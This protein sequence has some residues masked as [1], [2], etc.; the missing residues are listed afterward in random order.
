MT[1]AAVRATPAARIRVV[2]TVVAAF[3]EDP[4]FNYFFDK[5][6]FRAQAA[7]L[8]GY[9]FDKRVID[10]NVWVIDGGLSVSMWD[11]PD[12]D[13]PYMSLPLPEHVVDR[14]SDFEASVSHF[15]PAEPY[16][17]LG[18]LA[19]HPAHAGNRWGRQT[20][21]AGLDEAAKDELPAYLE[22]ATPGNLDL[23]RR[24]GW[25]IVGET[26][27]PIPAWVMRKDP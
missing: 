7:A 18:V 11:S 17:Y 25:S 15:L 19:T 27:T 21:Q 1:F 26:K 4:A 23:Y 13:P 9:L 24:S 10:G 20:M 6:D 5:D 2:D 16:W 8:A 3:A 12:A 14:I 22:T